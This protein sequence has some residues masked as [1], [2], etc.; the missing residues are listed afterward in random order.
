MEIATA[1]ADDIPELV[2]LLC[3]LFAQAAILS[4]T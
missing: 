4:M 1:T 3:I 2:N